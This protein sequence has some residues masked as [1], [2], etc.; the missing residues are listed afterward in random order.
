MSKTKFFSK[1]QTPTTSK[2]FTKSLSIKF[3]T[4]FKNNI[5]NTYTIAYVRLPFSRSQY[6]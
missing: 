3:F 1:K 2:K 6:K 4:Q 5:Q